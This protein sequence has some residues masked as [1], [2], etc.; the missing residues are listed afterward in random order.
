MSVRLSAA[1]QAKLRALVAAAWGP[2]SDRRS[3]PLAGGAALTEGGTRRAWV[4]IDDGEAKGFGAA[5][6]WATR[7]GVEHLD[8][9][10]EADSQ[11]GPAGTV[12]R[13]AALW[14]HP[15]GVWVV[16]GRQLAVAEPEPLALAAV[17]PEGALAFL[18]VLGDHGVD[19][20]VEHGVVTGEVL[21]LEVVRIVPVSTGW[22]E[23]GD[24][25]AVGGWRMDVGVGRHDR[26]ARAEM[27]AGQSP[28]EALDEVVADVRARRTARSVAH[29]ANRLARERWLRA[30]VVARPDLVGASRLDPLPTALARSDLRIAVPAPAGGVDTAGH[31]VVVV[32]SVGVDVDLVATAADIRA[33]DLPDAHLVLVVPAGDDYPVTYELAAAL[34]SPAQV[35]TVPGNWPALG[36]GEQSTGTL[37]DHVGTPERT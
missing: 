24:A 32:C 21:G 22:R 1:R 2:R 31:S 11:S 7:R 26:E 17:A 23:P 8:V 14:R 12:A 28:L 34:A 4:L 35:V 20:T 19:P 15:P 18:E 25:V 13:R 16:R 33:R 27:R 9:L 36:P 6:A 37:V 3:H 10:V 30:V 5:V 29:P